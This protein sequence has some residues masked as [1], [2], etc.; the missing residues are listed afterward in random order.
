VRI[1]HTVHGYPPQVGGTERVVHRLSAGLR[2][3]GH[4]VEVAT[5]AH[6][7]RGETVDGIRVHGFPE[8]PRGWWAYRRWVWQGVAEDRWDVVMTY[9][10]KVWT[11]LALLPFGDELAERWVY[12]PV[13]FTDLTSR[14]PRHLVYYRTVEPMSLSRAARAVTLTRRD[15]QRAREMADDRARIRAIPNGV[16]HAWWA[17]GEAGDVRERYELPEGP[18]VTYVGGFWEH[19]HVDVLVDAI[20]RIEGFELVL[21]GDPRGRAQAI[22]TRARELGVADRVHLL[23]RVPRE[24]VRALYHASSVHASASDTEGFGLT[25]LE[26]MACGL[27]VVARDTGIVPELADAG[28]EIALVDDRDGFADA[29]QDLG[30]PAPGNVDVAERYDWANVVD[31]VEACYEEVAE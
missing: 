16:D 15:E 1:L 17:N 31:R 23:G 11:H 7:E 8:T 27:P 9:H 6:P 4:A 30:G 2:D 12:M 29:I 24:D 28:A 13:E 20:A 10:S 22:R 3:R 14:R 18:L 25:F 26:A 21:A 19:K 5:A